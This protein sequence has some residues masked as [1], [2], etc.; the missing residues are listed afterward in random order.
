MTGKVWKYA[1]SEVTTIDNT[2]EQDVE[3]YSRMSVPGIGVW[4][5]KMEAVGPLRAKEMLQQHNLSAANCIPNINSIMPYVLSPD[6]ADP[7]K[8]VEAF[9]PNME[10]MAKL[11]PESIVVITG[12][13]GDRSIEEVTDLCLKG[14]ARIGSAA[15]DL[16]VTITLEPIHRSGRNVFT[17]I[18]DIPGALEL[19]R[20]LQ[21]P[22]FRSCSTPGIC[23]TPITCLTTSA[24]TLT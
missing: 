14:F 7:M 17:T 19:L 11:N 5:F 15:R 20:Q 21:E 2:F 8:R 13:Q 22:R 16:G 10:S 23:G 18:W 9:L 1:I 3:L 6:P 24:I 12:P 4:G